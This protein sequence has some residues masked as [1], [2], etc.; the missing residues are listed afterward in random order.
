M[1][2][3]FVDAQRF[4]ELAFQDDGAADGLQRGAPHI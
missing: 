3:F 4:F 1:A 2:Q